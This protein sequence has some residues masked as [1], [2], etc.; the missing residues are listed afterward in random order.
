MPERT[1]PGPWLRLTAISAVAGAT[2]VVA[3]GALGL[4]DRPSDADA[5]RAPADGRPHDGRAHRAPSS[6]HVVDGGARIDACRGRVRRRRRARRRRGSARAACGARDRRPR[7]DDGGGWRDDANNA[8]GGCALAR[9][10]HA[11]E[12]ADHEPASPDRCLRHGRRRRR[13]AAGGP[14]R[15]R[16]GRL[17]A[18]VRR[19][20]C[21]QSSDR[22]RPRP[23][24]VSHRPPARG[25]GQGRAV[26]GARVR[27][28]ALGGILRPP[29]HRRE[30]ADGGAGAGRE[31]LLR[32]RVHPRAQALDAPEHRHRRGRGS[33]P[34]ARRMGG[35][36]RQPDRACA[37]AL[38]DR[39]RLDA[40]AL[41]GPRHPD[42]AGLQGRRCP[43]AAG[44]PR[45]CRDGAP[46]PRLHAS[47]SC[48]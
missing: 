45:R 35:R 38:C 23:G 19:R 14:V 48:R 42:Q 8:G 16:H 32:C 5:R 28:R 11:H 40:T 36:D 9:L 4:G 2:L 34:A 41:L 26:S 1:P 27:A 21:A 12:A 46:D 25:S 43:H 22:P 15:C 30:P 10:R 37:R 17:G 18:R 13:G 29:V 3:S 33:R 20:Q 44:R 24:D 47:C 6:P 39:L 31:P 7:G